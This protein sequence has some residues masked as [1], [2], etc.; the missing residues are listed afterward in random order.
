MEQPQRRVNLSPWDVVYAVS[1]AIACLIA[2][3]LMTFGL[4]RLVD[5]PTDYLG[6]MWAAIA[7]VFVFR[8]TRPESLSAAIAR[9]LATCVSFA[10]CLPYLLVFP[11]TPIGMAALL[12]VGSVLMMLLGRRDEIITTAITTGAV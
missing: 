1:M 8:E 10:L 12:A 2:Y 5:A 9:L 6:G 4:A 7:A 11:S 3:W